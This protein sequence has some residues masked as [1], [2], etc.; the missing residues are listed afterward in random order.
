MAVDCG[1]L[2]EKELEACF[3][4]L[5]ETHLL[6]WHR[7]PDTGA[8]GGSVIQ[9]QPSDYLLALPPGS[10]SP[11]DGQRL[12]F[13][14]AKA[15]EKKPALSRAAMQ[16]AQRGAVCFYRNL[17]NLPYLVLFYDAADGALQVWDG[18]A[19]PGAGRLDQK[20]CLARLERA[21][22]GTKLNHQ[23]VCDFFAGWFQIPHKSGTLA[24]L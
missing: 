1:K 12:L 10:R 23:A 19:I 7:L 13:V 15:S 3:R 8:A 20:Y 18:A 24:N 9:A 17:L 14:E 6:G 21:G 11:L 16:P 22:F 4:S 2:F 5:K